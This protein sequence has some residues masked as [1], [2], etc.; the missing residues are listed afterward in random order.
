MAE[1][2]AG[3]SVLGFGSGLPREVLCIGA[4]CDDIEIGCAGALMQIQARQP[5]CR[6]RW[7]VFS[8]EDNRAEETRS[9]LLRVHGAAAASGQ[10]TVEIGDLRG[11][12]LPYEGTRAKDRMELVARGASPDVIFTHRLEDRHQDHRL[13][14]ELTWNTFRRHFVLEYEIP[15]YEG[16]LG[17]P[18]LYM[19]LDA[20]VVTRKVDMLMQCFPSQT[21]R[22]WFTPDTFRG[23]MRLRGVEC[24]ARSGFAEAFHAR[25]VI[26]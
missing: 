11:S 24:N 19:P 26:L 14:A 12:Y 16:D 20:D 15:K 7:V 6:F 13:L 22:A 1:I 9:A 25:K 5:G 3:G 2:Q 18:N 8:G 23:L 10:A 21:H 4:H 17:H